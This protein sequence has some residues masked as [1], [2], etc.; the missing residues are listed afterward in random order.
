MNFRSDNVTGA[1]PEILAAV[2]AANPGRVDGYGDDPLTRRVEARLCETFECDAAVFLVPTGTAANALCL[3]VLSPPYGAVFCH[4]DAHVQTDECG[5]PEFY[6]G[7]AKLVPLDGPGGKI[8]AETLKAALAAPN[9]GVHNVR[10]SAV[11][12]T[13]STE[14][15]AVY[16]VDQI[17]ALTDAAHAKGLPVHMDGARFANAL[18]RLGCSPA[19]ATWKAGVDA[20]SF[21]ATKNGALACEAVLLFDR[22]RAEDFAYRRKRG[23]HL[24]SKMRFLA[25]Q[26]DA[27][28]TDGLWLRLAAN[29][30]AMAT[31]LA[32]GLNEIPGAAFRT[33]VEANEIFVSLPGAVVDGLEADGF[34]FYRWPD[35]DP[36]LIRLV[37]AFD[38][39]AEEV[40]AL[41]AAAYRH[42]GITN[43]RESA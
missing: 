7:G 10:A 40:D 9:H 18:V 28:L 6:S 19:E 27:Y 36:N 32:D 21:G 23:G 1:A 43:T 37:T 35:A 5:A 24:F 41:L 34:G 17:R 39:K 20:L 3:S 15:G 42:A 33:P 22:A 16:T 14:F 13:Q 26:M 38:S 31:R 25:A 2:A 12:L 30:N 11:S 8:P 29:A 4:R